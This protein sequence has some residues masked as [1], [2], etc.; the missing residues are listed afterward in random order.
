MPHTVGRE[1]VFVF[2]AVGSGALRG[3]HIKR[4][5]CLPCAALISLSFLPAGIKYKI[6]M[7]V[8]DS[9][10]AN[11]G[12]EH[13]V[14]DCRLLP[15]DTQLLTVEV[16]AACFHP[17]VRAC[18]AVMSEGEL[19]GRALAADV[20]GMPRALLPAPVLLDCR[21]SM[22]DASIHASKPQV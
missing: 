15:G 3:N 20:R 19:R 6:T 22:A 18:A 8:G 17:I 7:E 9:S 12:A 21:R 16:R 13:A 14:G 11:D 5:R 1:T 10:C 4:R 2:T